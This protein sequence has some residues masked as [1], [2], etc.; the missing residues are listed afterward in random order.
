MEKIDIKE[1]KKILVDMLKYID[2]VCRNNKIEYSLIGGSLIGAIRH[3]GMIPWDDDVDIVLTHD[4][5]NKLIKVLKENNDNRYKL[6]DNQS[7]KN[8]Y[9]PF[10]KLVDS[11]TYLVEPMC[12]KQIDE[13]GIYI[14]IFSYNNV[15]DDEKERKKTIKKLKLFNKLI[16]RKKINIKKLSFSKIIIGIV[17]NFIST[18]IGQKRLFNIIEKIIAN[19]CNMESQYC[20]TNWPIYSDEKEIQLD[21]NLKDYITVKFEDIDVMIFKNYDA[22]LKTTFGDYMKLPPEDKRVCHGLIAYWRDNN[23]K[24]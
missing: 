4:N 6:L 10:P 1:Q 14:D 8:Y 20:I 2:N 21:K 24:K 17:R 7:C 3:K 5:Y 9:F 12:L 19:D 11:S 23:E 16:S 22:V 15:S 13:Y 18:I